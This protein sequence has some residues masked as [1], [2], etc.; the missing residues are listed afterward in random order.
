MG[1]TPPDSWNDPSRRRLL[2]LLTGS[3]AVALICELVWM[4]RLALLGGSTGLALTTTL[5]IYM[6]GLGLGSLVGARLGRWGPRA[7]GC[8]ELLSA[9]TILAMPAALAALSPATA[10]LP[11]AGRAAVLSLALLPPSV[12]HGISL[13][14]LRPWLGPGRAMA[15]AY[16]ANTAGAVAGVL[17]ATHLLLPVAGLRGTEWV[18]AALA[19][20][21]G[22][23]AL[24]LPRNTATMTEDKQGAWPPAAAVALAA[25]CGASALALE[26]C[27]SRVGAM[28]L[29]GSVHALA[30]VL[31]AYLLGLALGAALAS[32]WPRLS[33]AAWLS[34]LGLAVGPTLL[35]WS[36]LPY[37]HAQLVQV[38]GTERA[39]ASG[40]LLLGVFLAPVPV[41]SGA[42]MGRLLATAEPGS[43]SAGALLAANTA[44]CVLGSAAAGLW[45]LPALGLRGTALGAGALAL[46][47]GAGALWRAG[48]PRAA[49][50]VA[51]LIATAP[52]LPRWD[53]ALYAVGLGIRIHDFAD[54]SPRAIDRF[55]HEGWALRFY[56][57]GQSASV[58][59]GQSE[60]S[61]NLWL[62]L[63][64]KVDASTGDDMPTQ[65][66]S[67]EL[68]VRLAR[69]QHAAPAAAVVGLASGVT[70]HAALEAGAPEVTVIELEPAVVEAATHFSSA[71][72][73]ILEDPRATVVVDDARAW[74][75]RP[76]PRWPVI[77]SEP[78][79]PWLTGVSNLFT[80]EYW[81]LARQRLEPDGVFCQW[82]Q[83]YALP[84]RAFQSLVRSF[85]TVFPEA[86]LFES[87]PGADALLIAVPPGSRER[88][89]ELPLAPTLGPRQLARLAGRAPRNTDDRPWV[90]FEAPRWIHRSTGAQNRA[91]IEEARGDALQA[92]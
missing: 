19:V 46:G 72:G 13:P 27:W 4:R 64:G 80:V 36:A 63:N 67:G 71:N 91:L 29:G 25:G 15:L 59:V 61:G 43:R 65:L 40:A 79:N 47:L 81:Q 20:A 82:V 1:T 32:R 88:W 54:V 51:A 28:L 10:G 9:A 87:I 39:L 66:L 68:P 85:L 31:A 12:L 56:R 49:L 76:G 42:C 24:A 53:A 75:A 89:P 52:V 77:I 57:D 2:T 30:A 74:L 86:W 58:A 23:A 22:G 18:A 26:L 21:V 33:P 70:A 45:G 37:L 48:R 11:V 16:A 5:A 73:N 44:G 92:E 35:G 38:V 41:A 60:R 6:G 7:Y 90:E 8:A 69:P 83:L 3:G 50:A 84:P 34:G 14:A 17:L 62:S 78:S 55:A